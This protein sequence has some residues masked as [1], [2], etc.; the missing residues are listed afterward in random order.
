MGG[1]LCTNLEGQHFKAMLFPCN[2]FMGQEPGMP[3]SPRIRRMS[4]GRLNDIEETGQVILMDKVHVN[5]AK[6]EPVFEFLRYNSSLYDEAKEVISPIPWN[7]AKF[8]IDPSGSVFKY[9]SPQI[10]PDKLLSDIQQ[11][12]SGAV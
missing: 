7:F 10:D 4:T 2:Q 1:S 12:L 3:D 8:L 6:A 9:Y 5:G 11:L